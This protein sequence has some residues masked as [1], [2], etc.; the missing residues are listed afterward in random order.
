MIRVDWIGIAEV[1]ISHFK[2]VPVTPNS[3]SVGNNSIND[4]V[5]DS[6]I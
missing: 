5:G 2:M 4:L 3:T 1:I 6:N